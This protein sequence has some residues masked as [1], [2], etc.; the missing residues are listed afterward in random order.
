MNFKTATD[1][2][3]EPISHEDLATALG[4]S[5]PAIRQARLD[6]KAKAHRKPPQN[7]EDAVIDLAEDRIRQL[8]E[9]IGQL[10]SDASV[11]QFPGPT[12]Q[13]A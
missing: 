11:T 3:F 10:N 6:P 5:V 9:L 1:S 7:W 4:V 13:S 2:L 8:H 12:R